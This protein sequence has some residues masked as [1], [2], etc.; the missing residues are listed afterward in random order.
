M[1]T[2][3]TFLSFSEWSIKLFEYRNKRG[4]AFL[5]EIV[6]PCYATANAVRDDLVS[7]YNE[8]ERR[9]NSGEELPELESVILVLRGGTL[10]KRDSL[11]AQL[12]HIPPEQLTKF[13]HA[14][15]ALLEGKHTHA[16]MAL[17][18]DIHMASQHINEMQKEGKPPEAIAHMRSRVLQSVRRARET[19]EE[20]WREIADGY[21]LYV[22]NY[23]RHPV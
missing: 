10:S 5:D 9:L 19:A 21:A 14:I 17:H 18:M 2:L 11:R 23:V 6:K 4:K 12:R 1:V 22:L 8:V 13:E 16:L 20:A 7:I 15:M 3:S